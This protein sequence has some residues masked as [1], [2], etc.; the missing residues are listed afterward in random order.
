MIRALVLKNFKLRKFQSGYAKEKLNSRFDHLVPK[1]YLPLW[2]HPAGPQT[3]FFWAPLFK[4]GLVIA[5][6]ADLKRDPSTISIQ[7][8]LALTFTGVIWSR[9]SLVII[10]KNYLLFSVNLFICLIQF[11]QLYRIFMCYFVI[12]D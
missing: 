10:P 3:V 2:Q 12:N 11:F 7:Q 6:L 9:Y 4:W 8:T 5:G 1:K